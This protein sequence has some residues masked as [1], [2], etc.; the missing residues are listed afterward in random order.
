MTLNTFKCF[1][2]FILDVFKY[3]PDFEKNEA[4]YEEIR[5]EI[6]GGPEDDDDEE[7]DED[8]GGEGDDDDEILVEGRYWF[9]K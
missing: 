9:F 2:F 3:D 7:Q 4:E 5:K 6:I 8:G 1:Y